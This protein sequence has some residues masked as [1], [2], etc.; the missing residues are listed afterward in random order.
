MQLIFATNNP[1]KLEEVQQ[2]IG[3]KF[4]IIS[5]QQIGFQE[6]IPEP[7]DT[8][9]ANAL[10]KARTIHE[11]YQLNCF[12]EDTGLEVFALNGEPGVRSA[13]Y[14]GEEKSSEA[15]M[16]LVLKKLADKN[17]RKARFRT[18][19]ALIFNGQEYLFEGKVDGQILLTKRGEKG[20]GYDPIFEP[21]GFQQSFAE[22]DA[23]TKNSISHRGRAI[24][25]LVAFLLKKT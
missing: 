6:D 3:H 18:V 21:M 22:M 14:A 9:E 4:D 11:R 23:A 7:F 15:N 10:Q 24:E 16:A 13:R 19:A 12:A 20:F 5:L 1:K 17:N 8:L 25:K 2:L